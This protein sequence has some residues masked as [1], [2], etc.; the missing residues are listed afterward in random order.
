MGHKGPTYDTNGTVTI[1][2]PIPTMGWLSAETYAQINEGRISVIKRA[3]AT[4]TA[5]KLCW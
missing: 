5:A 3:H 1:W 4:R 2:N